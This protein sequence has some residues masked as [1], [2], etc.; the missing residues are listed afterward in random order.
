MVGWHHWLNGHES[1]QTA[2]DSG[3]QGNLGCCSPRGCKESDT[4]EWLKSNSNTFIKSSVIFPYFVYWL[5][6]I[7]CSVAP[8]CPR[9]VLVKLFPLSDQTHQMYNCILKW[10]LTISCKDALCVGSI[11]IIVTTKTKTAILLSTYNASDGIL[12]NWLMSWEKKV[13]NSIF[14]LKKQKLKQQGQRASLSI[15]QRL[16]CIQPMLSFIEILPT[17]RS[18]LQDLIAPVCP[19]SNTIFPQ[20]FCLWFLWDIF[21]IT[22][23]FCFAGSVC[24]GCTVRAVS[25]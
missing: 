15:R 17:I 13:L 16:G 12:N 6:P 5:L 14:R 1:E 18:N 8:G 19:G 4:V 11:C 22:K 20:S 3:G 2:G 23:T 21:E 10:P 9:L 24:M 25:V 7:S